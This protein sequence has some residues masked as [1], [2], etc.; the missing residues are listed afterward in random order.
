LRYTDIEL[1]ASS[2]ASIG[3]VV[4]A[5]PV[6][7]DT[8]PAA[9]QSMG[10]FFGHNAGGSIAYRRSLTVNGAIAGIALFCEGG[11]RAEA[12]SVPTAKEDELIYTFPV[13]IP[14]LFRYEICR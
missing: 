9:V 12:L 5:K 6:T 1:L 3:I 8:C 10:N 14:P 7:A 11:G 2:N 13:S 4:S